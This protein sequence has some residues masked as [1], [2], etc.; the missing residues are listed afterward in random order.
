MKKQDV[1]RVVKTPK[2]PRSKTAAKTS[3]S[4]VIIW[5]SD[6]VN[7]NETVVVN[8]DGFASGCLVRL[9]RLADGETSGN[10]KEAL[11]TPLVAGPDSLKVVVPETWEK[12]VYSCMIEQEGASSNE[13][14]VNGPDI[15]WTQGDG[16]VESATQAGWLRFQG[17]CLAFGRE[18]QVELSANGTSI[19]LKVS[20][21]SNYSVKV[22]IP[23]DLAAGEY[24]VQYSNGFGG[25]RASVTLAAVKI[26]ARVMAKPMIV[27][28]VERGADPTGKRDSTGAI[29]G[30]IETLGSFGGGVVYFPAGRYRIDSIL[31][32]GYFIQTSLKL[33]ENVT[34]R[35]ESMELVSLWWPDQKPPLP[36]LIEGGSNFGIEELTIYTQGKHSSIITGD[37]NV[38]VNRVRLR[39]NCYYMTNNH[40]QQHHGRVVD[41]DFKDTSLGAAFVIWGNNLK[42]TNCDIYTSNICFDIK[43]C[44]GGIIAN[45]TVMA[46]NF[47]F[48]SGCREF[49]FENNSFTGNQLTAGGSNFALHFGARVCKHTYLAHNHISHI[50]GGDHEAFTLDGHGNVYLGGVKSVAGDK[51]VLAQDWLP[52]IKDRAYMPESYGTVVYII[53]GK[54]RGQYRWLTDY[55]GREVTLDSP[56]LVEPDQT[57][58]LSIGAFN[59]RHLI[60]GNT[61]SDTGTAVQLYPPNNECIVAE[62]KTYR[63]SNINCL[64]RLR[65]DKVNGSKWM[66]LSWYNQFLD[67]E[68]VEGN[69]WGGGCTEVD[70]WIGGETCLNLW[71]MQLNYYTDENNSGQGGFV[72]PEVIKDFLDE[73]STRKLSIPFT[74][75]TVIR[76]HK[77][78]NNSS[79]RVRGRVSETL[80]E[81]CQIRN[82][83]RGIRIDSELEFEMPKELGQL[84]DFDP[85][86]PAKIHALEFLSPDQVLIRNNT[87][88]KVGQ[89][90]CGVAKD[91]PSV[92]TID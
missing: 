63:A 87:F 42:I 74:L 62:N 30:A 76:R 49:I 35:G 71:G 43:H 14:L 59:G 4:P 33:P 54:G 89:E 47:F 69:C 48:L 66:E 70:R 82:S 77:I 13:V 88:E 92:V 68:I 7:P 20:A 57:S 26:A 86:D 21:Y 40:G 41:V 19:P 16:G 2:S 90:Y 25:E 17:K 81:N 23:G 37:S 32:S 36:S 44:H 80:I 85:S 78:H 38:T 10:A 58:I 9:Q 61:M 51:L 50:Y 11:I 83:A 15:W 39:V 12:G 79:I 64:S 24:Q 1:N 84:F 28:V 52:K 18:P 65:K 5:H 8:G 27:N 29:V 34:L 31:R 3:G 22:E 55:A 60:V 56:W 45:N 6:P 72:T 91:H 53:E 46:K 75:F 67:N 73:T